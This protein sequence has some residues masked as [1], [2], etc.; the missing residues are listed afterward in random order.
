M[1]VGGQLLGTTTGEVWF[2]VETEV[3]VDSSLRP[4]IPD[5]E[6]ILSLTK[7]DMTSVNVTTTTDDHGRFTLSYTPNVVGDWG[8]VVLYEGESKSP[9][10]TYS[11]AYTQYSTFKVVNPPS[12]TEPSPTP[13]QT[14]TPAASAT[15]Q[16]TAT[17]IQNAAAFPMEYFVII[18]LIVIAI[19]VVIAYVY[20]KG[21]KTT[22]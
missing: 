12:Q 10:L 22:Q 7:P 5:A 8:W 1:Q 2:D 13:M 3:P 15:P 6:V 18:G 14:P 11:A 9:S 20:I 21:K 17:P 16:V 4:G 19:V